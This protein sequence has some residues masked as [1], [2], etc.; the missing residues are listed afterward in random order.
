MV[1]LKLAA[2][3]GAPSGI[4]FVCSFGIGVAGM[5]SALW[6]VFW[7][8]NRFI[9][10][11]PLPSMQFDVLWLPGT[12]AGVVWSIGNFASMCAV[13]VLGEAV[14]YSSCQAA[15]LVSGLWGFFYFREAPRGAWQ[16]ACGA[17]LCTVGIVLL[18]Q[19]AGGGSSDHHQK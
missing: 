19:V 8:V 14:G 2:L 10:K 11:K 7:A 1:P 9:R 6:I 16:W 18:S 4:D 15:I 17:I 13:L 5:T 3:T 12:I